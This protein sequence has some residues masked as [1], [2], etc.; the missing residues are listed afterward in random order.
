VERDRLP[1]VAVD[2]DVHR[3]GCVARRLRGQR[4]DELVDRGRRCL[5]PGPDPVARIP[6]HVQVAEE[7]DHPSTVGRLGVVVLDQDSITRFAI[8]IRTRDGDRH[9]QGGYAIDRVGICKNLLNETCIPATGVAY[10]G[11]PWFGNPKETYTYDPAKATADTVEF[12]V[13]VN[14]KVRA[15]MPLAR[16][17]SQDEAA[18]AALEDTNVRRF[19]EGLSVRKVVF[20]PDR[21]VNLVAG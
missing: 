7:D 15:R 12:V 13:Q 1:G 9:R 17:V 5:R 18:A 6:V 16:G 11:H 19:L 21:L 14:G 20:V 4:G 2:R 10:K 8:P 3:L